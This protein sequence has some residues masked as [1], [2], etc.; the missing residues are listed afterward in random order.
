MSFD[1]CTAHT[2]VPDCDHHADGLKHTTFSQHDRPQSSDDRKSQINE[3][4]RESP[5]K[6]IDLI[7]KAAIAID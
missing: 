2:V 7:F 1:L 3:G 4:N 5:L 6:P